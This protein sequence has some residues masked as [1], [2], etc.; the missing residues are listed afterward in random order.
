MKAC[1][2]AL[3]GLGL[4]VAPAAFADPLPGVSEGESLYQARC[5]MCHG[6][7]MG[8]APLM[9]KLA[10]LEPVD[11]VA[12][13]ATGTMAPMSAGIS[14][15]NLRDIAAYVTKKPLPADGDLPAVAAE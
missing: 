13:M 8:G 1:L 7:G 14:P 10:T 4:L 11:V 9:E 15:E 3:T 2:S 12:K 6:T 5:A